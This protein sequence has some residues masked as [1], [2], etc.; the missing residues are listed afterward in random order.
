LDDTTPRI[1]NNT[2]HDPFA[3]DGEF[4]PAVLSRLAISLKK[5]KN[6]RIKIEWRRHG[7]DSAGSAAA[8][9][10]FWDLQNEEIRKFAELNATTTTEVSDAGVPAYRIVL[11]DRLQ[12]SE[13]FVTLA[14]EL[15]HIFCGHLGP[16]GS[17]S[18]R[19]D[20]EGGWP[21]RRHWANRK[22]RSRLKRLLSRSRLEPD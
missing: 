6:F 2:V 10:S 19:D 9:G 3:V 8:Q 5:Q 20:D 15:A 17:R 16:C 12:P 13:Q 14:H 11:N 7:R 1:D 21:D 4:K 22:R 18:S